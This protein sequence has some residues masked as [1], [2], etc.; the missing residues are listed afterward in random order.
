MPKISLY[1]EPLA[2]GRGDFVELAALVQARLSRSED[3]GERA[4]F[5]RRIAELAETRLD[6]L[7][8]AVDALGHAFKE[9]GRASCRERV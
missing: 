6:D 7:P 5:W 8:R 3:A 4:G 2:E 9:I 1:P